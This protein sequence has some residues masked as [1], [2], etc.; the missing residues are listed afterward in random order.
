MKDRL[1][2]G[3]GYRHGRAR[4]DLAYSYGLQGHAN[5]SQSALLAGEYSHSRIGIGTQ[6]LML[7]TSIQ[8]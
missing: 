6:A 7:T 2:T 3:L 1:T 5:V 8:F 4:F